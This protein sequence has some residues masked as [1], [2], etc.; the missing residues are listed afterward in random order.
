MCLGSV[1][2]GKNWVKLSRQHDKRHI[3]TLVLYSTRLPK[4]R[5]PKSGGGKK[6]KK[7]GLVTDSEYCAKEQQDT[8]YL[9][10]ASKCQHKLVEVL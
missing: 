1:R 10:E 3:H 8:Q 9:V 4:E 7:K 6:K 2:V 5:Y